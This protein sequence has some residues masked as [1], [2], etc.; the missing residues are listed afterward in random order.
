MSTTKN[1]DINFFKNLVL[2]PI[3]LI[4]YDLVLSKIAP[5]SGGWYPPLRWTPAPTPPMV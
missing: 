3:N 4:F 2:F 5:T 1:R